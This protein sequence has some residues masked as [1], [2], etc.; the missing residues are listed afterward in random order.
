MYN[1]LKILVQLLLIF[2]YHWEFK[3]WFCTSKIEVE[4]VC[5]QRL[6]L[7]NALGEPCLLPCSQLTLGFCGIPHACQADYGL[8]VV[9]NSANAN[10][11]PSKLV[12]TQWEDPSHSNM[13]NRACVSGCMG[14]HAHTLAACAMRMLCTVNSSKWYQC[15][16]LGYDFHTRWGCREWRRGILKNLFA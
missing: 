15:C 4:L 5:R 11:L 16:S 8:A 1:F 13:F 12:L 9:W 14:T 7:K 6:S 2:L 10:V 3:P